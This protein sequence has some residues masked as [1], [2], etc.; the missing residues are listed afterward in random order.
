[1]RSLRARLARPSTTALRRAAAV[2][3]AAL[4]TLCLVG[5]KHKDADQCDFYQSLAAG[6]RSSQG[7]VPSDI[8]SQIDNYC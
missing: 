6:Y 3:L 1:M 4:A 5:C 7:F 8:Q 2:A